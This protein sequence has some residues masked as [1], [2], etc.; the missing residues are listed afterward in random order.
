MKM[1]QK[2]GLYGLYGFLLLSFSLNIVSME[3]LQGQTR[4]SDSDESLEDY[5]NIPSSLKVDKFS[6]DYNNVP[7]ELRAE[8]PS[9]KKHKFILQNHAN[10]P[11]NFAIFNKDKSEVAKEKLNPRNFIKIQ[12]SPQYRP[13][14]IKSWAEESTIL[15]FFETADTYV[16]LKLTAPPQI[17]TSAKQIQ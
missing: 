2:Y 9:A 1:S 11:L 4:S 10:V 3:P 16:A 12:L 13:Y 15:P 7:T 14:T 17:V 8:W 5:Q 6:E